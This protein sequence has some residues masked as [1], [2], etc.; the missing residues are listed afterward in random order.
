MRDTLPHR[1][2][3]TV[4][5]LYYTVKQQHTRPSSTHVLLIKTQLGRVQKIRLSPV[6]EKICVEEK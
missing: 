1:Q 6:R 2:W 4:T 5:D 3:P